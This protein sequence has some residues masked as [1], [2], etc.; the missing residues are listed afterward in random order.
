MGSATAKSLTEQKAYFEA[1]PP[2]LLKSFSFEGHALDDVG[3]GGHRE[4]LAFT[5]LVKCNCD[6]IKFSLLAHRIENDAGIFWVSPIELSCQTCGSQVQI[7]DNRS[8]GYDGELG[9]N[10]FMEVVD[11]GKLIEIDRQSATPILL[12]FH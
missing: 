7:F 6:S 8:L 5:Y 2:R 4:P 10:D 9:H 3:I 12:T 1:H 11:R